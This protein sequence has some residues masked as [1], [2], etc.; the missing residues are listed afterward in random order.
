VA[1]DA[2]TGS[3]Q[4]VAP[5]TATPPLVDQ[6]FTSPRDEVVRRGIVFSAFGTRAFV[7]SG[8]TTTDD[9]TNFPQLVRVN[10]ITGP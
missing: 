8:E 9:P 1:V 3:L 5:D 7:I 2:Q 10:T 6:P 4:I